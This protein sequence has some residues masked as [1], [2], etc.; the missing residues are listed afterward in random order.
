MIHRADK[1]CYE[2]EARYAFLVDRQL[3]WLEG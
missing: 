1:K 2:I 3:G